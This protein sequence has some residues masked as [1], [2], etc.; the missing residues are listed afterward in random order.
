MCSRTRT[1]YNF[2][3]YSRY[4]WALEQRLDSRLHP[5]ESTERVCIR[6]S[7]QEGPDFPLFVSSVFTPFFVLFCWAPPPRPLPPFHSRPLYYHPPSPV[8]GFNSNF[9]LT[10]LQ[11]QF[12]SLRNDIMVL[13]SRED[14]FSSRENLSLHEEELDVNRLDYYQVSDNM[15]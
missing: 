9:R 11:F 12:L 2:S 4:P 7:G 10:T 14:I 8:K 6:R 3:R 1:L 15:L 5:S 13:L